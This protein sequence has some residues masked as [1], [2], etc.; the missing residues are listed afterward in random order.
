[1]NFTQ[2][3]VLRNAGPNGP[4]EVFVLGTDHNVY[5]RWQDPNG[6]GGWAKW[7]NI[8]G[9]VVTLFGTQ[10]AD[11]SLEIFGQGTNHALWHTWQ[12]PDAPGGW[13]AWES[14]GNP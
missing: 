9:P 11:G 2:S 4:L 10:N 5:H 13:N 6:P 14:L 7:M 12:N 1:M 8:G 3:I